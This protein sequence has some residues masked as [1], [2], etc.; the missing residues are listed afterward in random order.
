MKISIITVVKNDKENLKITMQ[1]ILSQKYQNFE[2]IIFDGMSFD[3]TSQYIR[4]NLKNRYVYIRKKDRNYYDGLN[5]AIKVAKGEYIGILNAGDKYYSNKTLKII[6]DKLNKK[7]YDLL[8]GNLIYFNQNLKYK[9]IWKLPFKKFNKVTALKIA[10]PTLFIKKKIYKKIKYDTNFSIS[11]DT[12]FNL[13]IASKK[14]NFYYIDKI[15]TS[16]KTGGLSTNKKF[17]FERFYQDIAILKKHFSYFFIF[18]YLYKI[19]IKID[20]YIKSWKY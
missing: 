9:R 13:R 11:S 20:G 4:K 2:Y 19:L 12:D 15:I 16:M 5:Q 1:S 7:N 3:G 18:I 14:F 8:F 10:S 6:H 17:F